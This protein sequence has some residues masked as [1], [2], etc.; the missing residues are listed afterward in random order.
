MKEKELWGHIAN[1]SCGK[2]DRDGGEPHTM[3]TNPPHGT[4]QDRNRGYVIC[5]GRGFTTKTGR[6]VG[7]V[8]WI[9]WTPEDPEELNP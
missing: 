9:A 8:E 5:P 2:C 7:Y 4:V 6:S 1:D 3:T